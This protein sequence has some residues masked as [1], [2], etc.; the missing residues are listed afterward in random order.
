LV[1][2][3]LGPSQFAHVTFHPHRRSTLVLSL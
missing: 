3:L 1:V 2:S